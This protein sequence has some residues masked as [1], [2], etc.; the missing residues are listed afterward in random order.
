[1]VSLRFV[2]CPW[3]LVEAA[4]PFRRHEENFNY[5]EP[6]DKLSQARLIISI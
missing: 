2:V 5:L 3:L 4:D 1:V 6:R